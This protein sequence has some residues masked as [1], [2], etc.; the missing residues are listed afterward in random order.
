MKK[1]ALIL[2]LSSFMVCTA[3]AMTPYIGVKTGTTRLINN[4]SQSA[5]QADTKMFGS[6]VFG[7]RLDSALKGLAIDAEYTYRP[8]VSGNSNTGHAKFRNQSLMLNAYYD[9][10]ISDCRI[11][12]YITF[13]AGLS[14]NRRTVTGDASYDKKRAHQFTYALG[15]GVRIIN[16][17]VKT[18]AL[19][20]ARYLDAG[21]MHVAGEKVDFRSK[22]IY[23]GLNYKF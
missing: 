11:K 18:D 10:P 9:L 12:P 6:A 20:G 21:N 7:Y 2:A 19:I 14:Q 22:E 13:G 3:Q 23:F 8:N 1:T 15:G 16:L 5:R 17:F 4:P